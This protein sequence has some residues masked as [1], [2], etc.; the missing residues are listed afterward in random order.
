MVISK[1]NS[2]T[3]KC[4]M[5]LLDHSHPGVSDKIFDLEMIW[6][7]VIYTD[8]KGIKIS[9]DGSCR[10]FVYNEKESRFEYYNRMRRL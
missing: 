7:D 8:E 5:I 1:I 3:F 6:V 4:R 2:V 9:K 10:M